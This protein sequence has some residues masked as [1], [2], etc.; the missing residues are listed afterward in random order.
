MTQ[1]YVA[2][3]VPWDDESDWSDAVSLA[4]D[5]LNLRAHVDPGG[6]LLAMHALDNGS[7][8]HELS[9][10]K[11]RVTVRSRGQGGRQCS[12]LAY[13]PTWEVMEIAIASAQGGSLCV[14]ESPDYPMNGWARAAN[15]Q[16]LT[17]SHPGHP[18]LSE[19]FTRDMERLAFA[20]NNG[21]A[22]QYGKRDARRILADVAARGELDRAEVVG[23]ML[24][25]RHYASSIRNLEKLIREA[26]G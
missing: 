17:R 15:A 7:G 12:V 11:R 9:H 1:T 23:A 4:I 26:G 24:L 16:D 25:R 20:G 21:W 19:G 10:F 13:V 6:L 22:D 2:A 3:W 18:T 14:I 5:W 8:V